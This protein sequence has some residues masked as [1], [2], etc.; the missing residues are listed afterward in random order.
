MLNIVQT[1]M[2][3]L[4]FS[5]VSLYQHQ[6]EALKKLR[7]GSIL[8]GG[9]GSGKSITALTY[10][11]EKVCK[12]K[13][14]GGREPMKVKKDLYII[15]T[16]RKRD[17]LEGDKE[18]LPFCITKD[19]E[20]QCNLVIDSWNN[21]QKYLD[22]KDAFFIFDEQRVVGKGAWAKSFIK[23][24]KKNQWILLSATPGDVWLD[25]VPVFLANGFFK[26]RTQFIREHVVYNRFTKFPKVDRYLVEAKLKKLRDS[27]LVTMPFE[28]KAKKHK[29][30]IKVPH[31]ECLWNAISKERWNAFDLQPILNASEMCYLLRKAVNS[32]LARFDEVVKLWKKHPKIIIFYNFD[33]ELDILRNLKEHGSIAEWNGHKHESIPNEKRWAYLVQYTAGS[34]GWNCVETNCVIFYSLNYSYKTMHQASGRIDRINTPF[35]DLY[36]YYLV[37]N[38]PIDAAIRQSLKRKKKFNDSSWDFLASQEFPLL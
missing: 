1:Q 6:E 2:A 18:F 7:N 17:T 34:E 10:F 13:A 30:Y 27:I 14:N 8:C 20:S 28:K 25:Y 3:M 37:S 23:I 35:A 31:D 15:T 24:A 29:D 32:S 11:V 33:Y 4:P 16:A 9:V 5:M 19:E 38:A 12:G 21:I 36:Y 26:N 22:I